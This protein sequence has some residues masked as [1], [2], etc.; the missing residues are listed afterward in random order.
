[1]FGVDI[2]F[3]GGIDDLDDLKERAVGLSTMT[4]AVGGGRLSR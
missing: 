2:V 4:P 3:K 1:M